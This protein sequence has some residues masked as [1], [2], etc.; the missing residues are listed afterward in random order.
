MPRI[1]ECHHHYNS[2]HDFKISIF[3]IHFSYS[4]GEG[5]ILSQNTIS[6]AL[7]MAMFFKNIF[8]LNL[9]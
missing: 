1:S 5:N 9:H 8:H 2:L 7:T 4:L 3:A 6:I